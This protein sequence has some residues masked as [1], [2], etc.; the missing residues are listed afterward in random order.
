MCQSSWALG[1]EKQKLIT[2]GIDTPSY[3]GNQ[4]I[5][6]VLSQIT[7]PLRLISEQQ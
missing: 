2:R 4:T 3:E 5:C 1:T 7:F 6:S